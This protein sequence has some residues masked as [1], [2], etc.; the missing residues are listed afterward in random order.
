MTVKWQIENDPY[1][2]RVLEKHWPDVKRFG[3]V[4][5]VGS[6]DL[7]GVDL[8]A[9]GFPCQDISNAGTT[10]A[11]G[12]QGLKGER[13]GLWNEMYRLVCDLQPRWVLVE[14]VGA[15]TARGLSRVLWD[16]ASGGYDAVWSVVP[17]ICLG[18]SHVRKRMFIVAWRRIRYASEMQQCEYTDRPIWQQKGHLQNPDSERLE[19][20]ECSILAQPEE[21]RS[22]PNFTGPAWGSPTPRICGRVDGIPKRVDRIRVTGNSVHPSVVCWIGERIMRVESRRRELR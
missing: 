21:G 12:L 10:H 15:I 9:G 13:S 22:N 8:L 11:G 7:D 6:S 20:D 18:A 1:C 4:R 17:A 5:G 2:L 16:F 3:D 14:N 19:G